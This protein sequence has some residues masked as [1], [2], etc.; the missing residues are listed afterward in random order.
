[1]K[2]MTGSAPAAEDVSARVARALH[3]S[4]DLQR[5]SEILQWRSQCLLQRSVSL[6]G[7]LKTLELRA[8]DSIV[9]GF[10]VAREGR[11]LGRKLRLP[12]ARP[13]QAEHR[14]LDLARFRRRLRAG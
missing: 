4:A 7:E 8:Q 14:L 9:R 12:Y 13:A 2:G 1:M 11:R 3:R 10:F 5:Q 6:A